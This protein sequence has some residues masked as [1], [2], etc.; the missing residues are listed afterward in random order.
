MWNFAGRQNQV[1]SPTPGD[2]FHGNWESGVKFIDDF[3]LGDQ[4]DAPGVLADDKGKNHYYFLPLL[5][6]LLGL[7]FQFDRDKRG[8]WLTFL[9]FFMTGIAI[10]LYLNQPPY[11]VRERDYAFA[12]S[13]YFF[14]VWIG[15]G[16]LGIYEA[17]DEALHRKFGPSVAAMTTAISQKIK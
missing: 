5:L 2:L 6:G 3:R 15:L 14:T 9:M 11:Q 1:H 7:F 10:V 17:V 12:G 13:F 16:V 4:T 8:S